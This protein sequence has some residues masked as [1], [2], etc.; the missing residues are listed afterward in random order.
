MKKNLRLWGWG[1]ET[2]KGNRE[3]RRRGGLQGWV[4][5]MREWLPERA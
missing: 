2:G 1:S 4:A 3:A 5:L